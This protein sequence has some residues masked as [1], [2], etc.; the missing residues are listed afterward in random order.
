MGVVLQIQIVQLEMMQMLVEM[1][2]EML[3]IQ[4][5]KTT[6]CERYF[7]NLDGILV[8]FNLFASEVISFK[9]HFFNPET[10]GFSNTRSSGISTRTR[11]F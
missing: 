7:S 1:R 11:K 8:S 2:E 4:Q 6:C 3:K 5:N 10:S 9:V